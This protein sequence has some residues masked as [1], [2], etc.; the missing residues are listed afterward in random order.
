MWHH[1]PAAGGWIGMGHGCETTHVLLNAV[2]P[3][4][5]WPDTHTYTGTYKAV[6]T[7]H[8][9][10]LASVFGPLG[11]VMHWITKVCARMRVRVRGGPLS[12][13]SSWRKSK[14]ESKHC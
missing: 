2:V 7:P 6:P 1:A 5:P 9:L 4:S 14:L 12:D 13:G 10:L 3:R 11:L 8:S